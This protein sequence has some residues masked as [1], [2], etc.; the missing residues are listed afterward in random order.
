M[1]IYGMAFMA[2]HWPS[3]PSRL[4]CLSCRSR[5]HLATNAVVIIC[6]WMMMNDRSAAGG[7]GQASQGML[8][9][10]ATHARRAS[11]SCA[12]QRIFF[13]RNDLLRGAT[14]CAPRRLWRCCEPLASTCRNRRGKGVAAARHGQRWQP[15][16]RWPGCGHDLLSSPP[17]RISLPRNKIETGAS[18][19]KL[20]AGCRSRKNIL[21]QPVPCSFV[22]LH[23]QCPQNL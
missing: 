19:L 17:P 20:S 6:E 2:F 9:Q 1:Y 22:G 10:Q 18:E 12:S 4:N 16:K 14:A 13:T 8:S 21:W 7:Q 5:R 15:P 23:S 3:W 11:S